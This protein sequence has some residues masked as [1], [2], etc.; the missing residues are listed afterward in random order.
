MRS[1]DKCEICNTNLVG[2]EEHAIFF[3]TITVCDNCVEHVFTCIGCRGN[4]NVADGTQI[5]LGWLCRECIEDDFFTCRYCGKTLQ[6]KEADE[7]DGSLCIKCW[8]FL[9]ETIIF[10]TDKNGHIIWQNKIHE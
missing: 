6:K 1:T 5:D 10:K 2:K 3:K 8:D 7:D 9:N 4:F